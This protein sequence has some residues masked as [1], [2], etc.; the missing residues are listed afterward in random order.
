MGH[1]LECSIISPVPQYTA[2]ELLPRELIVNFRQFEGSCGQSG[3]LQCIIG[4]CIV[5]QTLFMGLLLKPRVNSIGLSASVLLCSQKYYVLGE[6][7]IS[8]AAW[9]HILYFTHSYW[10]LF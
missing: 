10:L 3:Q 2:Q 4:Q 7:T 1:S 8:P 5:S 6:E 9:T